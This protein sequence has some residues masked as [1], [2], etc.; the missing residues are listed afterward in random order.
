MTTISVTDAR[1]TLPALISKV[2]QGD[3]IAITRHGE[4]V[5]V[6]VPPRRPRSP[7]AVEALAEAGRLH[8]LV[9]AASPGGALTIERAEELV[10]AIRRDRDRD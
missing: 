5:A 4:V 8:D 1:T 2:Q 6:L 10:A 7:A 3:E 9:S